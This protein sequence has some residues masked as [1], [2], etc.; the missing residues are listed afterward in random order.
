[1]KIVFT[2]VLRKLRV[3]VSEAFSSFRKNN[4]L[5]AASSLAFS[6]MLALIPALFLLT[7]LV[8]AAVGSSQQALERMQDVVQ[9]L[10]PTYSRE[11]LREV[12]FLT[13]HTTT[14]GAV[15]AVLLLWTITPLVSEMRVVLGVVFKKKAGRPFL[16]EKL[17]DV[18]ITIVFLVALS[19][20]AAAGVALAL[21][22]RFR[23]FQSVPAYFG[24]V[25]PLLVV[26]GVVFALYY[27]FAPRMRTGY[28]ITG[29]LVTSLLWFMMRPAFTFFLTYNPGYGFAF[30]SFKSSFVV[31][32]WIYYSM[33]VFL[34]GAET[35]ASLGRTETLFVRKLMEGKRNVPGPVLERH[36]MRYD[37]GSVIFSEG[38]RGTE[39]FS[40]LSGQVGIWK[41]DK[42]LAVV[43]AGKFFGE[44]SF[45]LRAPRSATA[46]ALDDVELVSISDRTIATLMNEFPEFVLEMLRD[47][48]VRLRDTSRL[49][50]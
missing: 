29:A 47:V 30:G 36:V 50:V 43:P 9:E 11:I 1:M 19:A 2:D 14:I 44:M 32:I 22:G 15:N 21:A 39:M 28:F 24:G 31:L 16:L 26:A 38:D 4:D 41:G 20:V 34:F 7:S 6:A 8:G 3:V 12:R 45:L 35:V 17:L 33:G 23:V 49:V 13:T 37:R 5:T 40:V 42:E 46:V 48:A 18:A 25:L 27:L 10:I